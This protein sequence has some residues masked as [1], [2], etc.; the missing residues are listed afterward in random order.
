MDWAKFF[1]ENWGFIKENKIIVFGIF[2]FGCLLT[3]IGEEVR[4]QIVRDR[5][6]AKNDQIQ[7]YQRK[8]LGTKT[9]HP[10]HIFTTQS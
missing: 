1:Y 9:S 3:Y 2:A 7:E 5:I 4:Y 10:S 8:E 6:E